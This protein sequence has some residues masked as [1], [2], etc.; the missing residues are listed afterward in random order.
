MGWVR[1]SDD[2][3]DNDKLSEV[4]PLGMALHLASMGFCNRNL[5][6][7][8]IRKSKARL[9]LDFDGIGIT[10][11]TAELCAFGVDGPEAAA[12][13]IQW[14]VA[15]GLWHEKGH[16]CDECHAR[17][18]GGEPDAREY[19]IHD[20]LKFQPSR[21]EIEAKAEATRKRVEAWR[22]SRKGSNTVGNGVGNSVTNS[23]RTQVVTH[24]VHDTPTPT[25]TPTPSSCSLVTSSGGVT[26]SNA[27]TSEPPPQFCSNHPTG[28]DKPCRPCGRA[29]Q[30]YEAWEQQAQSD[31]LES[32][33]RQ[34]QQ[35]LDAIAACPEC[36]ENG[37]I[38]DGADGL[39]RCKNHKDA[40]NA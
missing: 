7:G 38:D 2:F 10:T 31:E 36:D 24:D 12:L 13:V 30:A 8:Y 27:R 21:A 35:R 4:G 26:E 6:D 15:A 25:P 11:A 33:R 16:N 29:R 23:V 20:Y 14:M 39:R 19:L 1:V 18:D 3:Y 9:L 34:R 17:E 37:F 5:T 22:E 28:T 40:S 32:K